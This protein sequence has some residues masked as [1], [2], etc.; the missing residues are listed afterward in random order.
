MSMIACNCKVKRGPAFIVSQVD[1][2]P[3]NVQQI[4]DKLFP[5][6]L[7]HCSQIHQDRSP[8]SVMLP[9]AS[10]QLSHLTP[11]LPA[12]QIEDMAMAGAQ[13]AIAIGAATWLLGGCCCLAPVP[14]PSNG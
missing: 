7:V 4:V 5:W 11:R 1:L 3:R 9:L 10:C 2:D 8:S 6:M 12:Y 14:C 13:A